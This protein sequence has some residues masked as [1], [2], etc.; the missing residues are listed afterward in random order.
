MSSMPRPVS[1]P[2][3][4]WQTV[5][6]EWIG[7]P[8]EARLEVYEEEAGV[9]VTENESPDVG[10]RFSVNPY[11]GCFHGCAYCYAR[12]YHEYLDFGAGTDFERKIVVKVNAAE[13]LERRF[14]SRT[15][16]GDPIAFSGVTDC[17]QPLEASYG[18]TRR[19]LEVCLAYRNPVQVVTKGLLIR[20][21]V[22]VLARLAREAQASVFFTIPFAD[23]G[24]S[25]KMEP[26]APP[27][28]ARFETLRLLAEAGIETGIGVAPI[29]P[30]L[31]ESDI[32]ALLERAREAGATRAF[33]ILLRLPG[34]VEPVFRERLEASFPG[35][36]SKILNAL[37]EM[38]A[39][40]LSGGAFGERMRGAGPRWRMIEDLFHAT[41]RRLGL[42]RED[43]DGT[44]T[45]PTPFRRPDE[46][47]GLFD[48]G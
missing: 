31:N 15:W 44:P 27:P 5:H 35:R 4:P 8:P 34:S 42:N 45:T 26:Y 43:E 29:I 13:A 18:L 20:R 40:R 1:T 10:F 41:C 19:C 32:P 2:P 23:P 38:R 21:D 39:G 24:P 17:Y 30:G 7:P 46:T 9:V 11:R 36:A 25:R 47:P 37:G 16:A 3:N 28:A 12:P 48:S 6:V 33:T 22:D 14:R